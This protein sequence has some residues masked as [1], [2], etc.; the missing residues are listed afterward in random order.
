MDADLPITSVDASVS[1]VIDLRYGES[2]LVV[3]QDDCWISSSE[4][5]EVRGY[6]KDRAEFH[7]LVT[8]GNNEP[9]RC[10]SMDPQGRRLAV[11][12]ECAAT[13]SFL[14]LLIDCR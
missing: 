14:V 10:V 8:S 6:I 1:E 4:D 12:S 3:L 7:E 13:I 9:V 5:A 2:N 11:T